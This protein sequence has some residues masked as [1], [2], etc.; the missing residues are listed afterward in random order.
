MT[1]YPHEQSGK[2]FLVSA[3][4]GHYVNDDTLYGYSSVARDD[5]PMRFT[6]DRGTRCL[7]VF[8]TQN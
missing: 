1:S 3:C 8:W 7:T 5:D 6:D 2:I 4:G